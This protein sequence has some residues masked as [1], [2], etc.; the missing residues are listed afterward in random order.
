MTI[1]TDS[2]TNGLEYLDL[3]L[4]ELKKGLTNITNGKSACPYNV[5][6]Q[7]VIEQVE[8]LIKMC[9]DAINVSNNFNDQVILDDK[10]IDYLLNPEG[11]I[12]NIE[13]SP[14]PKGYD[15]VVIN[16]GSLLGEKGNPNV[17]VMSVKEGYLVK[18]LDTLSEDD[19]YAL[20]LCYR[21]DGK[22]AHVGYINKNCLEK[23]GNDDNLGFTIHESSGFA[24]VKKS[25]V[26]VR[27]TPNGEVLTKA[28]EG[29]Y[30]HV[31]GFTDT[32]DFDNEKT[33]YIVSYRN[34]KGNVETGFM[35]EEML[36]WYDSEEEMR[37][38]YSKEN[39]RAVVTGN[40]VNFRTSPYTDN[41]DNIICELGKNTEV[42]VID[43][44]DKWFH[45]RY[46]GDEGYVSKQFSEK[47]ESNDIPRELKDYTFQEN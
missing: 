9:T 2:V 5:P 7:E 3:A 10:S 43:E 28:P 4:S 38:A 25:G 23:T 17:R 42:V 27:D 45:I 44:T 46:N 1:N 36:D 32:P 21:K 39:T 13:E 18:V 31:L 35:D 15:M 40:K 24:R 30:V 47:M 11:E 8:Y 12:D 33:W 6:Y 20:V 16:G 14:Y 29:T 37:N 34:K 41:K 26:R 22:E 19:Q